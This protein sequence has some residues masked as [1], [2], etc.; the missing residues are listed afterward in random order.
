M[1]FLGKLDQRDEEVDARALQVFR[2]WSPNEGTA[3]L[4]FVA[5]MDGADVLPWWRPMILR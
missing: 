1:S 5:R 4:Q 2:K 3:F